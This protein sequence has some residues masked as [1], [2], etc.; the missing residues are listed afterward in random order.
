M[1]KKIHILYV[2]DY[3]PELFNITF[4]NIQKYAE[5]YNYNIN[6]ITERKFPDWHLHYEKMQVY[7]DG[8]NDDINVFLD[9]D[10]ML[11]PKFPDFM[12]IIPPDKVAFNENYNISEK[13]KLNK[14]FLRDGRDIGIASNVVVSTY[15][16][17]DIWKPLPSTI[18]P[19]K[20][21]EI[22]FIREGDIDEFCLSYNLAKYGLKHCGITWEPWMRE[23]ILHTGTSDRAMALKLAKFTKKNWEE[24][25]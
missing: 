6:L 18:T 17:H 7:N 21:R 16:T 9:M 24:L 20:G 2:N 1:K 19:E 22:T 8:K 15:L 23:Y 4:T 14:Y 3:F 11:H 10:V 13:C 5:K 12:K 25:S